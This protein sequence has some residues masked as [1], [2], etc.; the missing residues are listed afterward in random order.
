MESLLVN[1]VQATLSTSLVSCSN[2]PHTNEEKIARVPV[3]DLQSDKALCGALHAADRLRHTSKTV[4]KA[5][6]IP[7]TITKTLPPIPLKLQ[8][9][10]IDWLTQEVNINWQGSSPRLSYTINTT[11]GEILSVEDAE[12]FLHG[13][14]L[15]KL[16]LSDREYLDKI[17]TDRGIVAFERKTILDELLKQP[18]SGDPHDLDIKRFQT[19][20]S[21]NIEKRLLQILRSKLPEHLQH[22]SPDDTEVISHLQTLLGGNRLP[23]NTDD[24]WSDLLLRRTAFAKNGPC[25]NSLMGSFYVMRPI[26]DV[27][28]NAVKTLWPAR[29]RD[30]EINDASSLRCP[31]LFTHDLRLS[32]ASIQSGKVDNKLTLQG[33]QAWQGV[34]N[35]LFRTRQPVN[36]SQ[37]NDQA[38]GRLV[39]AMTQ[40]S[41]CLTAEAVEAFNK[42]VCV[43]PQQQIPFRIFDTLYHNLEGDLSA[44]VPLLINALVLVGDQ[45]NA[46]ERQD[47]FSNTVKLLLEPPQASKKAERLPAI[48]AEQMIEAQTPLFRPIAEAIW[49][50][51]ESFEN[52]ISTLQAIAHARINGTESPVKLMEHNGSWSLSV[53]LDQSFLLLPC[54]PLT[55]EINL[56]ESLIPL[57]EALLSNGP[58]QGS[59]NNTLHRFQQSMGIN[60]ADL[61]L[62]ANAIA[63]PVIRFRLRALAACIAPTECPLQAVHVQEMLDTSL[64]PEQKEEVLATAALALQYPRKKHVLTQLMWTQQWAEMLIGNSDSEMRQI[65]IALWKSDQQSDATSLA[66]LEALA[67]KDVSAAASCLI[68]LHNNNLATLE[69]CVKVAKYLPTGNLGARHALRR[70]L[71][72]FAT[73]SSEVKCSPKQRKDWRNA[74]TPLLETTDP[75]EI[76]DSISIIIALNR[77]SVLIHNPALESQCTNLILLAISNNWERALAEF[78]R[79]HQSRLISG[80]LETISAHLTQSIDEDQRNIRE[81]ISI[82]HQFFSDN[83]TT[84]FAPS[85]LNLV[86]GLADSDWQLALH[87]WNNAKS[88]GLPIQEGIDTFS[89]RL[90]AA[91]GDK[92]PSQ[93]T[94]PALYQFL[95]ENT[96]ESEAKKALTRFVAKHV[97]KSISS[98]IDLRTIFTKVE[99]TEIV[100]AVA[101]SVR[102]LIDAGKDSEALTLA[103]DYLELAKHSSDRKHVLP[104]LQAVTAMHSQKDRFEDAMVFIQSPLV[105][106]ITA[107]TPHENLQLL[108]PWLEAN[109]SASNRERLLESILQYW[110][111]MK[112]SPMRNQCVKLAEE[113]V[114]ISQMSEK[115]KACIGGIADTAVHALISSGNMRQAHHWLLT[116]ALQSTAVLEPS[117]KQQMEIACSLIIRDRIAQADALSALILL[118]HSTKRLGLDS[119]KILHLEDALWLDFAS[120][121]LKNSYL[122]EALNTLALQPLNPEQ[123]EAKNSLLLQAFHHG[124]DSNQLSDA[125]RALQA[126]SRDDAA[127]LWLKLF[128]TYHDQDNYV[129]M[130]SC[131]LERPQIL[132]KQPDLRTSLESCLRSLSAKSQY[133]DLSLGLL[134]TY[135]GIQEECWIQTY[136]TLS[137]C[138]SPKSVTRAASL[139]IRFD[140]VKERSAATCGL[141]VAKGVFNNAMTDLAIELLD[142]DVKD[143][144]R[145]ILQTMNDYPDIKAATYYYLTDTLAATINEPSESID[146]LNKATTYLTRIDP[147]LCQPKNA[148]YRVLTCLALA[149]LLIVQ[150]SATSLEFALDIAESGLA[151]A[152][153]MQAC[154]EDEWVEEWTAIHDPESML[155]EE[156]IACSEVPS[157]PSLESLQTIRKKVLKAL[158]SDS[159]HANLFTLSRHLGRQN[160][161]NIASSMSSVRALWRTITSLTPSSHLI[162]LFAT[163]RVPSLLPEVLPHLDGVVRESFEKLNNEGVD[164]ID[165]AIVTALTL[166]NAAHLSSLAVADHPAYLE[167]VRIALQVPALAMFADAETHAGIINLYYS[168]LLQQLESGNGQ[169]FQQLFREFSRQIPSLMRALNCQYPRLPSSIVSLFSKC[170][171]FGQLAPSE[172]LHQNYREICLDDLPEP[173]YRGRVDEMEVRTDFSLYAAWLRLTITRSWPDPVAPLHKKGCAEALK[174]LLDNF[175]KLPDETH[176]MLRELL[177]YHGECVTVQGEAPGIKSNMTAKHLFDQACKLGIFK[178]YPALQYSLHRIVYGQL[179]KTK[180]DKGLLSEVY[181][182]AIPRVVNWVGSSGLNMGLTMLKEASK[183]PEV[184]K[185]ELQICLPSILR[186]L[187]LNPYSLYQREASLTS[188]FGLVAALKLPLPVIQ[189]FHSGFVKT[190][191]TIHQNFE[192]RYMTVRG[193]LLAVNAPEAYQLIK[194][195]TQ[196]ILLIGIT[197]RNYEGRAEQ[198]YEDLR[199]L[200]PTFKADSGSVEKSTNFPMTHLEKL[201]RLYPALHDQ[202]VNTLS[203]WIRMQCIHRLGESRACLNVAIA[204]NWFIG[205][206]SLLAELQGIHDAQTLEN[207]FQGVIQIATL[208]ATTS[209]S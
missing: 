112:C 101:R 180:W 83:L 49:M 85:W 143:S 104:V 179:P 35:F 38:W 165:P 190:L 24:C 124:L 13:S 88:S 147:V 91:L 133:L 78:S 2:A 84:A 28:P 128:E 30:I 149:R 80:Q 157:F 146:W 46:A 12:P 70:I 151:T 194:T 142:N 26:G 185:S 187:E 27:T 109:L 191:A 110:S 45:L 195:A 178:G 105:R 202:H 58:L 68:H 39:I 53:P 134:E 47:I 71:L 125:K 94:I 139:L 16:I 167:T 127:E 156:S 174:A 177:A 74:L 111:T 55:T 192:T 77:K 163:N 189:G 158:T 17:L 19:D 123:L 99:P 148:H 198:A 72:S 81:K 14:L 50:K 181:N 130:A 138:D 162:L 3:V 63:S 204:K 1:Q 116:V 196:N 32:L 29:R 135:R 154:N 207:T 120:T 188:V 4:Q 5:L 107:Q 89:K 205:H 201:H 193:G 168:T 164:A 51:G 150:N 6:D 48:T 144:E 114:K 31:Q 64:A 65:G 33:E 95:C 98:Q 170:T 62:L 9:I 131:L 145:N 23:A 10:L 40:G 97:K 76:S 15:H 141:Y 182:L 92:T 161:V 152:Q 132:A 54:Q 11:V 61:H 129:E 100:K 172:K 79:C 96:I 7:S 175:N 121:C 22:I 34:L 82:L 183:H 59:A 160:P 136:K 37:I 203:A 186:A 208:P 86:N 209:D 57:C 42:Q 66:M 153:L 115:M 113:L 25:F 43:N 137:K 119:T 159:V 173:Y 20:V 93:E 41:R 56:P 90:V 197:S 117:V 122:S 18:L 169:A 8:K 36:S 75:L 102:T 206:E 44:A 184:N 118:E 200:L 140:D 176:E 108:M 171:P 199:Q 52:I 87:H 73:S 69:Q 60:P 106:E 155:S 126:Y 67:S 103:K 166:S 21:D